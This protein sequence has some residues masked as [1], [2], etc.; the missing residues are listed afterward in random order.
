MGGRPQGYWGRAAMLGCV[1][2]GPNSIHDPLGQN[3]VTRHHGQKRPEMSW[4]GNNDYGDLRTNMTI[5]LDP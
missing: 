1:P 4:L 3:R 5:I 2:N